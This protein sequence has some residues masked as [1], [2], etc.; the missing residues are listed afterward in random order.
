MAYGTIKADRITYDTASGEVTATVESIA[1]AAPLN[2]PTFTGTVTVPTPATGDISTKAC[3]TAFV[4]Q[5][6]AYKANPTFSGVVNVT[7]PAGNDNSTKAATTAWAVTKLAD[8]ATLSGATFTGAISGTNLTLSGDLTVQGSTTTVS[9]ATLEVTDKNI[10]IGKVSTPTDVTADG[11]GITLKGA[12]DKT[13]NWIDSTDNWT[14]SEGWDLVSGKS[15][16]INNTSVLNSTTLG[17]GVVNSSLTSVGTLTG[18]VVQGELDVHG[19][20][21][22][23]ATVTA[24][25]LSDNTNLD[26]EDGNIFYFTTTETTTSTPNFRYSSSATL[27]SKMAVG[28]VVSVTVITTAAAAGYSVHMTVDGGAITENWMYANTPADG[29]TSGVDI[30]SY[31]IIKTASATFTV[32]GNQTK[33][34]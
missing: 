12:T 27:D 14:S 33:T 4:D 26:L 31:M 28:D 30:Y 20:L 15:Y 1:G 25:K 18:L 16:H 29:G 11:G 5:Y 3:T 19:L 13:I 6:F 10:E 7:T 22:E 23:Q 21:T 17:S 9:S 8:Y 34:S 32:I 2:N 24:G